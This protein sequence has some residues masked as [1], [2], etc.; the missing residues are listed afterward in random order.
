MNQEKI[1]ELWKKAGT[2]ECTLEHADGVPLIRFR[3]FRPFA[4]MDVAFSTRFGGVSAGYLSELN[5]GFG[6]GDSDGTV[7]ENYRLFCQSM[8]VP[9]ESLVLSDQVH[10]TKIAVAS[11]EDTC[12]GKIEKR[13]KGIDGLMTNEREVC[14]ATSYADCVPLFFADPVKRVI[15]S[16]HSGWRGTVARIGQKTVEKMGEKFGSK[17]ENIIVVIGP[18]ICQNCYEVSRD[19]I[20]AFR[21]SYTERQI[22]QISYCSDPFR[23]KYQLNLW[24]A[25]A[26]QMEEA[27]LLP[28]HIHISGVCTCCH[29]ELFFSHRASHGKR[30]NLNGFMMLR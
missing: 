29:P 20:E 4:F 13:W 25:N 23:Q 5:L 22:G 17:A 15:A 9:V 11:K 26:L 28:E 3:A 8:G 14:L 10:G 27:G 1:L 19:V 2:D 6:R 24:K 21:E 30:G 7:A 18:S 16:S 12:Q